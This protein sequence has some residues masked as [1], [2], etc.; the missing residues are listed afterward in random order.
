MGDSQCSKMGVRDV[1]V[2]C[3]TMDKE[4]SGRWLMCNGEEGCFFHI[5]KRL[6]FQ[7][8]ELGLLPKYRVNDP[9]KPTS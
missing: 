3:Q 9:F 4:L 5:F 7:V 8:K 1:S 2:F 6:D